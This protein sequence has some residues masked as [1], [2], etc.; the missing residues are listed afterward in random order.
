MVDENLD[1]VKSCFRVDFDG[2]RS[3]RKV[4]RNNDASWK[5]WCLT[6]SLEVAVN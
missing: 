3:T 2:T 6:E 5:F 1:G 4:V